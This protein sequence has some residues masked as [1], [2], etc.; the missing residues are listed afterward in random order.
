M[1]IVFIVIA[2]FF[3]AIIGSFLCCQ[4]RRLRLKQTKGKKLSQRSECMHCGHKLG[5]YENIPIVSWL[6]L[7]GRCKKCKKKIGVLEILSEVGVGVL[8]AVTMY[9]L[10]PELNG[11]ILTGI[12]VAVVFLFMCLVAFLAIYDGEYGELPL[13]V[14]T[15]SI[16]CAIMTLILRERW[17]F[18]GD[19]S[20][21]NIER[22]VS[23]GI[24]VVVF[25]GLYFLLYKISNEKWVGGGDYLLAMA[26]ALFL[27]DWFSVLLA[28]FFSNA[29]A[30]V[31]M[32]VVMKITGKKDKKIFFGPWMVVGMAIAMLI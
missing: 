30:A 17:L 26:I 4:A 25:A 22:L 8:F 18:S 28:I 29:L 23:A 24:G 5:W 12:R 1:D 16:I 13:A 27:G 11:E 15:I 19:F 32:M 10:L 20:S 2:F 6:M 9:Y 14:L 7:G 21:E 31:V 3:G